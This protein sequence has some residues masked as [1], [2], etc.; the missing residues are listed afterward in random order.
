ML[1]VKNGIDIGRVFAGSDVASWSQ[2]GSVTI[3][4]YLEKG[5]EVFSKQ[6]TGYTGDLNGDLFCSFSGVK[7]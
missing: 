6:M 4:T 3:V 5:D 7:I 1:L 2:M